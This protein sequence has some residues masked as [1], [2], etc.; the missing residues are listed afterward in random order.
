MHDSYEIPDWARPMTEAELRQEAM[1]YEFNAQFDRWDGWGDPDRSAQAEEWDRE[2]MEG[3][4]IIS[5]EL[6]FEGDNPFTTD[7]DDTPF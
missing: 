2:P 3:D 5:C 4:D 1:D 6:P 7:N